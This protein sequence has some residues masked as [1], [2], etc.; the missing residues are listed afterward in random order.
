MKSKNVI[1]NGVEDIS[2]V[3]KELN[4]QLNEQEYLIET[5]VSLISAGTELSR[6]FGLKKGAKYPSA[7]GYCSVGKVLKCG[8]KSS[9]IQP[10]DRVLFSAPHGSAHVFD[11]AKSDGGILYKLNPETSSVDGTFLMMC[12]I[13]MNGILPVDVKLSDTVAIVGLG[14]LGLVCSVY[15]KQMGCDVIAIDPVKKRGDVARS[16]G[17]ENVVDCRVEQQYEEVMKLTNQR[18]VD[19]VVD[20]SGLSSCIE[21]A[22]KIA[23][24][25]GQVVLMG[26]PRVDYVTNV[27]PTFNA[28]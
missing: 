17:I 10:D 28:I 15:Y 21:F 3:E 20:A 19:I 14:T 23:A 13:A 9:S 2:I 26:S 8:N 25:Y 7:P 18:G 24:M 27:T 12:W 1:I 5:E 6:V 4:E 22:V 11:P 16:L